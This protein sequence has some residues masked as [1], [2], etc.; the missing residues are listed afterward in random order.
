MRWNPFKFMVKTS[1]RIQKHLDLQSVCDFFIFG[2][3]FL[4]VYVCVS[5]SCS[6][7]CFLLWLLI[8]SLYVC[9]CYALW[10]IYGGLYV[11]L[12][13]YLGVYWHILSVYYMLYDTY[14]I[15]VVSPH[16]SNCIM[17]DKYKYHTHTFI[18]ILPIK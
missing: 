12:L 18:I 16:F 9:L 1:P 6:L 7:Y 2:G 15:C 10:H 11:G 4:C 8:M 17:N 13:T 5:L 3:G 14:K